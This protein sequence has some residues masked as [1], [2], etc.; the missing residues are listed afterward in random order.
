MQAAKKEW[1]ATFKDRGA[2]AAQKANTKS[3]YRKAGRAVM[4]ET[5]SRK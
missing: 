5:Q 3:A 1:M 4:R 2:T